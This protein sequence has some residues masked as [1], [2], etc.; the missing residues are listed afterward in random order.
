MTLTEI[1]ELIIDPQKLNKASLQG[2]KKWVEKY[3][4]FQ[5]VRLLY[6]QNLDVLNDPSLPKALQQA[7]LYLPD[8][9]VLFRLLEGERFQ[10]N[11]IQ[12]ERETP[13]DE[14]LD[15][16]SSLIDSFLTVYEEEKDRAILPVSLSLDYASVLE[17]NIEKESDAVVPAAPTMKGQHLID[18][19][20][21]GAEG[22]VEQILPAMKTIVPIEATEEEDLESDDAEKRNQEMED[23]SCFTETLAKIY[24]KQ[25][26][27]AKA[28]EIIKKLNLK[29]P[30]KNSYFAD[31]IRFL[32]KLIINTKSE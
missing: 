30:E 23:E 2:L 26:R 19:F 8:R 6:I 16:T 5:T 4:Y 7:A 14:G 25:G 20:I 18:S 10:L 29:Y 9:R 31:Q 27:Y 3:P 22:G 15:R 24:V 1:N 21:A 13:I 11:P 12:I 28:L 17:Q 32:E